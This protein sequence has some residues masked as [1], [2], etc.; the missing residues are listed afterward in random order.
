VTN[1]SLQVVHQTIEHVHVVHVAGEIDLT[2]ASDL[3]EDLAKAVARA[4]PSD[5]VV[6]DLTR[7]EFLGSSGLA[8]LMDIDE[9][10]RAKQ[11]RLSVVAVN[12]AVVRPLAITGLDRILSVVGSLDS[13][14]RS[15]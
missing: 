13:V 8:V 1:P 6:A 15:A 9:Q 2:N 14:I 7:V 10:C 11:T 12:P 4:R 3:R 5:V